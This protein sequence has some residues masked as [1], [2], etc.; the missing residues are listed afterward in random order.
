MSDA[1]QTLPNK[2]N[3]N[4]YRNRSAMSLIYAI[5]VAIFAQIF[6]IPKL[7]SWRVNYSLTC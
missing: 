3:L 7:S 5:G 4:D 1:S 2:W 6:I